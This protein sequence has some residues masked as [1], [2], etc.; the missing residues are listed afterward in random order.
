MAGSYGPPLLYDAI[1]E[2]MAWTQRNKL[3]RAEDLVTGGKT[4]L[5]GL[6]TAALA[7]MG[8]QLVEDISGAIDG[9]AC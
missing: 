8:H 2:A 9:A 4:T 5:G 1:P 3:P 7:F 6:G